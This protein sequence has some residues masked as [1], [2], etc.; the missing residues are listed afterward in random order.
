M[1]ITFQEHRDRGLAADDPSDV[2]LTQS[3]RLHKR[4]KCL[5]RRHGFVDGVVLR[6]EARVDGG[7]DGLGIDV[8]DLVGDLDAGAVGVTAGMDGDDHRFS[9]F[10]LG[11]DI[12]EGW[13]RE[14]AVG[15]G[16]ADLGVKVVQLAQRVRQDRVEILKR[17][18]GGDSFVIS[19][20]PGEPGLVGLIGVGV[21]FWELIDEQL[22]IGLEGGWGCRLSLRR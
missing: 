2:R 21:V 10:V 16:G 17:R 20:F 1:A 5:L 12:G 13:N 6:G 4:P 22:E 11:P 7:L 9:I 14:P 15:R 18:A 3:I 19:G 8:D